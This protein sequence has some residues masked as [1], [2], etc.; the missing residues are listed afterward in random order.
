MD[1]EWFLGPLQVR[2]TPTISN[3]GEQQG[4][5][6]QIP[7][8]TAEEFA[9][10]GFEALI[11]NPNEV[12]GWSLA[13][14][15]REA[16]AAAAAKGDK[17]GAHV[18]NLLYALCSIHWK[19]EDRARVWGPLFVTTNQRSCIPADFVGQQTDVLAVVVPSVKHAPLRARLADLVWSN[20]RRRGDIAAIAVDAYC[21]CVEGLLSGAFI[22]VHQKDDRQPLEAERNMQ[23]ALQIAYAT[24]KRG[25]LPER[26]K[27]AF[28]A[29]YDAAR[30][31]AAFV[32]FA[33]TAEL[34]LY[35]ALKESA[36][37]AQDAETV[38][39]KGE[40]KYPLP[41]KKLWD[42]AAQLYERCGDKEAQRRCK[43]GAVDQI[44]LMRTQVRSA[45]AEASW[46]MTALQELRHVKGVE[47]L[48]EKLETDLRR[49][50]RASVKEMAAIPFELNIGDDR[51][52]VV[53]QFSACT[54]ADALKDFALLTT[55]PAVADLK[56]QA[57]KLAE[58]APLSS[59]MTTAR[60]DMEGKPIT[61]TEGAGA[62]GDAS[63]EWYNHTID[64]GEQIRRLHVV[65]AAIDPARLVINAR[66]GIDER[67]IEP[68]VVCSA[69][70][71]ESQKPILVL[72]F[73]RFLQGDFMS[74]AHL[75][76]PQLEACLRHV[77]KLAGL[78]P[79]K[80]FDDGTEEDLDLGGMYD[81]MRPD[82]ER[83]LSPNLAAEVERVFHL[84]PGPALRH[85]F[86]HGQVSAG[87]C[88]GPNVVFGIWLMYRI[89][90]L[91]ASPNWEGVISPVLAEIEA[92]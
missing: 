33:N 48:E 1:R 59:M 60:V 92:S 2:R 36:D 83:I 34:G 15:F 70:A 84:R 32:V 24:N 43:L 3:S 5:E 88:F 11:R 38:A 12:N 27:S 87:Q 31:N 71:P 53:E 77:L 10:V 81:R 86:A 67:H 41:V 44:L 79:V 7:L 72:G 45:G 56:Q 69:F 6:A 17:T 89:C 19:P 80:R 62:A 50:Q 75:V 64:Q 57:L 90:W 91:F 40:G 30:D 14:S 51:A 73:T 22:S 13:S 54:L 68:I 58:V 4:A 25:F 23:R 21:E 49:L 29:L 16:A 55:S 39:G 35:F 76:L 20:S 78:S 61:K 42:M 28:H 66:F 52:K 63:E 47:E 8:V 74:A 46:V 37:V 85:D 9:A 65:A 18:L 26:V 82:L